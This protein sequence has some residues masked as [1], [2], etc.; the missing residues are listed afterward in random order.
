MPFLLTIPLV[1]EQHV[2]AAAAE[3]KQQRLV[4]EDAEVRVWDVCRVRICV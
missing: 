4:Y 3:A 1:C 2:A